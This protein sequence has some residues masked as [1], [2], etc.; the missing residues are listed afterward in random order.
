MEMYKQMMNQNGDIASYKVGEGNHIVQSVRLFR[1]SGDFLDGNLDSYF[2]EV[3]VRL[4]SICGRYHIDAIFVPNA[5]REHGRSK[6]QAAE[7]AKSILM[8][9]TIDLH[10]W[11]CVN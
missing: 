11:H 4:S 1:H 9:E 2:V 5:D 10:Y 7:M 3:N 8:Q 6:E